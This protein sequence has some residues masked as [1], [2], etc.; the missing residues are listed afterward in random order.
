MPDSVALFGNEITVYWHGIIFAAAVMSAILTAQIL[1]SVNKEKTCGS[2][3][4]ITLSAFGFILAL[5][6]ARLQYCYF[7]PEIYLAHP[8]KIF[9]LANGGYGLILGMLGVFFAALITCSIYKVKLSMV[10]DALSPAAALG[11]CIGRMAS[12]FSGDDLGVIVHAEKWHFFPISVYVESTKSWQMCVYPFEAAAAA[13][14]FIVSLCVYLSTYTPEKRTYRTGDAFISFILVYST[15]QIMLES[16]RNDALFLNLLGFVRF[17][18][19]ACA[20]FL[21]TILVIAS[22]RICKQY[23][24]KPI[25]IF[26]WL[27]AAGMFTLAFFMEFRLTSGTLIR[28]Y[29]WMF[30]AL[31]VIGVMTLIMILK[32][33]S[34][35]VQKQ[36]SAPAAQMPVVQQ[37]APVYTQP[38]A[39]A[40]PVYPAS[41]VPVYNYPQQYNEQTAPAGNYALF[42][43]LMERQRTQQPV[44]TQQPDTPVD[45]SAR[46]SQILNNYYDS[47][48]TY[49]G[50]S[51]PLPPDN[52]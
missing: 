34:I 29:S 42:R 19:V 30:F 32:T 24:F 25:Y 47:Q 10:L 28:N 44:V 46:L 26:Y 36:A 43:P 7:N 49:N 11:I 31:C 33:R 3:A 45:D 6:L 12:Y 8:E 5:P 39:P 40:A 38:V 22:V 51:R 17:T 4:M 21:G 2:W 14:A 1:W 50:G 35:P 9:Q 16:W 37:A 20:I 23:G 41:P 18:Q 52:R 15:F 27:L 13:V 48:P